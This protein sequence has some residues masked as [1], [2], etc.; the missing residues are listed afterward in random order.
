MSLAHAH[1]FFVCASPELPQRVCQPPVTMQAFIQ[2]GQV[3]TH[4]ETAALHG[5]P[6]RVQ[7]VGD[8]LLFQYERLR[9]L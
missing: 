1:G 9:R 4:R 7:L 8:R 2:P 3:V 5:L 6:E